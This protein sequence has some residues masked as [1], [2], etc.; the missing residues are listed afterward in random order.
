M[1][2]DSGDRAV[3]AEGVLSYAW[4][5]RRRLSES[6][7]TAAGFRTSANWMLNP[8][9]RNTGTALTAHTVLT[10]GDSCTHEN[11]CG[12]AEGHVPYRMLQPY[13]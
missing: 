9:S 13:R 7:K 2:S 8:I 10:A 6:P 5:K 3:A 4:L 11:G 12:N 1:F